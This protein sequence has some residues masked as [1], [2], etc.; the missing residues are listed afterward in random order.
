[1][2]KYIYVSANTSGL[3]NKSNHREM[4][5]KYSSEGWRFIAAIPVI[6]SSYGAIKEF[7]LVFE[8]EE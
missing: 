2:Y 3:F 7:D 4:I 1:M 5:D 6:F 8:K